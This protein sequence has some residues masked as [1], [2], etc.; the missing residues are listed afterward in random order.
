M[1]AKELTRP[2]APAQAPA[3]AAAMPRRINPFDLLQS[4]IDRVFESFNTWPAVF[5]DRGFSP[6]MEVTETDGSIEVSTELPGMDEKDVEIS[7]TDGMLTIRGEKKF[8][9]D[10]KKKH[11]RTVERSYGSFERAVALPQGVDASKVKAHMSK[12]VLKVDI[13]K[14]AAAKAQQVKIATE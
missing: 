5:T 2:A 1:T 7:V 6:T 14:P 12:G 8:E 10:E 3:K 4:E 11:Y 13:P 9:K